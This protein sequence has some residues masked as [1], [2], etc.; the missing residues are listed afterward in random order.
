MKYPDTG[1]TQRLVIRVFR[2]EMWQSF[3][4][5]KAGRCLEDGSVILSVT[6][7]PKMTVHLEEILGKLSIVQSARW[8]E[9]SQLQK[10]PTGSFLF[11]WTTGLYK[12]VAVPKRWEETGPVHHQFRASPSAFLHYNPRSKQHRGLQDPV[13]DG[14]G[15]GR[16]WNSQETGLVCS[17]EFAWEW[18]EPA[19]LS[20]TVALLQRDS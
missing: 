7:R 14:E 2:S 16:W 3:W 10:V 13:R 18:P 6:R 15:Q 11:I 9:R 4:I 12:D 8:S 17:T 5:L 20:V 19:S 1:G